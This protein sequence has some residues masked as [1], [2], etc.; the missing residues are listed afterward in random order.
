[1]KNSESRWTLGVTILAAMLGLLY[2]LVPNLAIPAKYGFNLLLFSD[3]SG[4][5]MFYVSLG[6]YGPAAA[7]GLA[8]LQTIIV[9]LP[10]LPVLMADLQV[11]GT[12]GGMLYTWIGAVGG[13]F[14]TYAI[15]RAYIYPLAR[16]RLAIGST[17]DSRG[18]QAGIVWLVLASRL[19]PLWPFD[20][21]PFLAGAIALAPGR[22][23]LAVALGETALVAGLSCWGG[24]SPW[25]WP[26]VWLVFTI[27]LLFGLGWYW[28]A[29]RP[30]A[31]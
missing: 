27:I 3:T 14:F 5:R 9:T 28:W 13:A 25:L 24:D 8:A 31:G 23:L 10:K 19:V 12:A 21:V 2:L 22:Y 29:K 1:M 18:W 30:T 17:W 26:I 20:L 6:A 7:I 15:G 16:H 4:L 11:F